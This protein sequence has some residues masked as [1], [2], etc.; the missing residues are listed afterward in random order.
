MNGKTCGN[1]A[2]GKNSLPESYRSEFIS[3]SKQFSSVLGS[4]PVLTLTWWVFLFLRSIWSILEPLELEVQ[5]RL[6]SPLH[7]HRCLCGLGQCVGPWMPW[8]TEELTGRRT[9]RGLNCGRGPTSVAPDLD[10]WTS[11]NYQL[12]YAILTYSQLKCPSDLLGQ[13]HSATVGQRRWAGWVWVRRAWLQI[14]YIVIPCIPKL[15][16]FWWG[17]WWLNIGLRG[18]VRHIYPKSILSWERKM[19]G[20][21]PV[22]RLKSECFDLLPG[23]F[24]QTVWAKAMDEPQWNLGN[25][26]LRHFKITTKSAKGCKVHLFFD[27]EKLMFMKAR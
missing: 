19:F 16:V 12:F 14:Q 2:T 26:R 21:A 11:H 10:G 25:H 18:T 17:E 27:S 20:T 15:H 13:A 9:D 23:F 4:S 6:C 7:E 5:A 22:P 3:Q 1:T 8:I 24:L